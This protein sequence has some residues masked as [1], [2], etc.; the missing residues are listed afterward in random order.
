MSHLKKIN[1]SNLAHLSE[2]KFSSQSSSDLQL[3]VVMSF[4]QVSFNQASFD[5][6]SFDQASFDQA[7][8]D[9]VAL[10]SIISLAS[11]ETNKL[12]RACKI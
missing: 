6:A 1:S 7:S 2:K 5:Q 9:Q 4:N 8:F 3:L 11:F 12:S 10:A